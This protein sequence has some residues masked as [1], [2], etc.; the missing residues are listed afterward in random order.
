MII[1]GITGTLGAGKGTIV[2][3]L[4]GSKGFSHYSV[5]EFLIE[6]ILKTGLPVNRDSMV[7]VANDLRKKHSPA[8]IA[9]VLY[10]RAL[11]SGK[12]CVIESIRTPGEVESLRKKASFYLLAVDAEP[13]LRYQRIKQRGSATDHISYD[14]FL[15]NEKREMNTDDPTRQNISRCIQLAD[16]V[17]S[18]NGSVKELHLTLDGILREILK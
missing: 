3:Y 4:T 11:A 10:D 15:D 2:E 18:N 9:E 13:L 12:N 16:F 1:I 8:Y 7:S 6:E 14:T 5:R 17:L